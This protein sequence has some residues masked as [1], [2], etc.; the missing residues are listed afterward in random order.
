MGSVGGLARET[1]TLPHD[2][3]IQTLGVHV[4]HDHVA[5][6]SLSEEAKLLLHRM[7]PGAYR[8]IPED[9]LVQSA[10]ALN[11]KRRHVFS[12][13]NGMHRGERALR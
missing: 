10:R 6:L 9:D 5:G 7:N 11:S 1:A 2:S 12:K 13:D 8:D 3:E 4:K